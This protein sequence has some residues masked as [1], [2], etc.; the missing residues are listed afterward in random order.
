[1]SFA[2]FAIF[3]AMRTGSNLLERTLDHYQGLR[4][5][6]EAFNS[7]FIGK[8]KRTDH[9]GVSLAERNAD[10]VG[11]LDR[12]VADDPDAIP[13]FRIFDGHDARMLDHCARDPACG[14][15]ILRRSPIDS[16]ISLKIA[17]TTG[18]WM[19][20]KDENRRLAK[21]RFDV[22]EFERYRA[23]LDAHYARIRRIMLSAG[24]P[25]A[26]IDYDALT[27]LD[28]VNG[29]AA[30][31]G[32]P[33]RKEA[34]PDR[35][36]RQ[37]PVDWADKVENIEEL[38]AY[39][40]RDG[41]PAPKPAAAKFAP[42]DALVAS[43]NFET[44]YA[45]V[46]GAGAEEIKRFLLDAAEDA[47]GG[48]PDLA[49]GL[50]VK[51]I[52]RR[53]KRG[54]FI[55]TF[56]RHPAER[57]RDVFLRRIAG[58]GDG[59]IP[60]LQTLLERDYRA[61]SPREMAASEAA[62]LAGFDAFLSFVADNLAGRTAFETAPDWIPQ[63]AL[64]A[65]YAEEAPI[66][67]VGRIERL[68][69]DAAYILNRLGAGARDLAPRLAAHLGKRAAAWPTA[70]WLTPEREDRIHEIFGRDY[71]RLGYAPFSR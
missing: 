51:H 54:A 27:D 49:E 52:E 1:M 33:E 20:M 28:A 14:K 39:A 8:P 35:I 40:G 55:F 60:A 46:P 62:R 30:M 18:Q 37:N 15:I 56:I 7:H 2:Y 70:A 22:E 31:I 59:A 16:F 50:K 71:A 58:E 21:I 44:I 67:F 64:I 32:S 9:L 26:E 25:A 12:L 13:G 38:T 69:E 3:G 10:P 43:R 68:E 66:D 42:L 57:A 17:Q 4:G 24:Q 65:A 41:F 29:L 11:Y 6:G 61:P 19:L 53:R 5:E 34:L 63:S 45:P 48:P 36:Q 47:G 23:L